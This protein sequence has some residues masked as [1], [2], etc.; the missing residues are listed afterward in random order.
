MKNNIGTFTSSL[1]TRDDFEKHKYTVDKQ[2]DELEKI[3]FRIEDD[4]IG[5]NEKIDDY[6]S[7]K[8]KQTE[9]GDRVESIEDKFKEH[10]VMFKEN[11]LLTSKSSSR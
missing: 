3:T 10:I 6:D 11:S 8:E 1:F 5:I 2:I 7:T 4:I 9:I